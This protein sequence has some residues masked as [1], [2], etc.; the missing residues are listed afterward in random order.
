MQIPLQLRLII[1]KRATVISERKNAMFLEDF[2][3]IHEDF[4]QKY[5]YFS[6]I[7][8]IKNMLYEDFASMDEDF[9]FNIRIC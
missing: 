3:Q 2:S 8:V 9:V 7:A 1:V 5:G 6:I 4:Q